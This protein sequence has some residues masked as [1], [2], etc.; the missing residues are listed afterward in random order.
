[1]KKDEMILKLDEIKDFYNILIAHGLDKYDSEI[2]YPGF[3]RVQRDNI[4]HLHY[5]LKEMVKVHGL[6]KKEA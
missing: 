1:M 3:M 4:N 6:R 2:S 5:H